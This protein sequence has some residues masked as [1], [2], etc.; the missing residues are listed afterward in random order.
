MKEKKTALIFGGFGVEG[1]I[2]RKTARCVEKVLKTLPGSYFTVEADSGLFQR[3]QGEKPDR[4][5]LGVHGI[6]GEDGLVQ[7]VCEF[8]KIPYT[9][10]GLLASALCMDK[11]FF[12]NLLLKNKIATPPFQPVHSCRD[13]P[14]RGKY[15]V[16]VKASH[17]GSTLG[18]FIVKSPGELPSALKKAKALGRSVF[19]E[20]FLSRGKEVAVSWLNGRILTPVEIVPKSGFYDY[21]HKY[22]TGHTDYILPPRLPSLVT[23]RLKVISEKVIA[24]TDVRGYARLDFIV[25][26]NR[27]WL[28][29]LN[30]LPGLT[31]TSLLPKSAQR[32]KMDFPKV[33]E[34]ILSTACL[35]YPPPAPD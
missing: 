2:S 14:A 8:L 15:P 21:K 33:I 5:F 22:E 35:D 11:L 25:K 4:A 29:E 6:Y 20:D 30:T 26:D 23:E 19:I 10:S 27:P 31:E 34:T 9:G 17:G 28:L 1:D 24:L 13:I 18:T 32:D 7:A 12:K 16:V 3:L